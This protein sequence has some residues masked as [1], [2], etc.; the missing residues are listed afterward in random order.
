MA[1]FQLFQSQ[2][3]K[4]VPAAN[5]RNEAGGLAYQR[6]PQGALAL[7]AATGCLNGTIYADAQTQLEKVLELCGKV[8]A[9]FIAK[10]AVY[11]R[12]RGHMKDMPALLLAWLAQHDGALCVQVFERV[13]D[14][15]RMLRNFVQ[16]VRSGTIGRKS[17]GSRP[18]RLVKQWLE[19][20]DVNQILHAAI[21]QQPSLA[22]IV[23]MVHPKPADAQREALYAWLIGKPHDAA[24]LPE[25]VQRFEA[26]KRG[27]GQ[28][29][30]PELNFQ[31]LTALP[32]DTQ[33]WKAIARRASWQT[34]RMNLNTFLRHGVFGDAALTKEI[35]A[36]LSDA[37]QVRKA[38]VFPYQLL[39]AWNAASADMPQA[40][41]DALQDAM[42]IATENTPA[43]PGNVVVAID[44]SG[45][46]H[47]P[48]TG[49][50]KGAT[51]ALRCVD[52]AALVAACIKR[53]NPAAR[54]LPF[55]TEVRSTV[56]NARDSV[57]TQARQLAAL[58]GGGTR[59]SA[60]VQ[61]LNQEGARVDTLV[62]V[63]DNESWADTRRGNGTA[64]MR[65][66]HALKVRCPNAKLVCIDLQP[67][68]TSQTGTSADV[69]HIAG[70]SDAVFDL[71]ADAA[72]GERDWLQ[73]IA[74]V[75][76]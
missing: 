36:G 13:V 6:T 58:C 2:R 43:L 70:F 7:Y 15:G 72:N 14:N 53:R 11:A 3:G 24:N 31:Y 4:Q 71:L 45:S 67:Y 27:E 29:E 19:R 41:R 68:A 44:V 64:T 40:I 22:D 76:L 26:F 61:K 34:K 50:R 39:G 54:I 16:I 66:W 57:I 37:A 49:H 46:M 8:P 38:R 65:E 48:V 17:L 51:S 62:I 35:A 60:P 59:V 1:N 73:R 20:A 56:I 32:L 5:A 55:D 21:G 25:L 12:Q 75:K 47:S 52:V 9:E 74:A 10:T 69:L 33:Q 23:R 42:E 28:G 30:V 63:S 18:K